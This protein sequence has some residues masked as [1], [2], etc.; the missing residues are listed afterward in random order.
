MKKITFLVVFALLMC[1]GIASAAN[2]PRAVDAVNERELWITSV[3]NNDSGTLD[4][5]DCVEW[6]MDGATG[7]NKNYVDQCDSVDT[8]LIAGVVWPV[9]IA[10]GNTGLIVIKGPVATDTVAATQEPGALVCSTATAGSVDNCSDTATD[11]NAVGFVT[12]EGTGNSA[13]VNVFLH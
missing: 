10:V 1:V 2:I 12:A 6:D 7:D 11:P 3:Y 9:D 8:F 4:A 13:V 5:G